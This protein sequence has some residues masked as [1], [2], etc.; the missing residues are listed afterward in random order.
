MASRRRLFWWTAGLA[1]AALG[2]IAVRGS[3]LTSRRSPWPGEQR[4]ALVGRRFLTPASVRNQ[5][6]PLPVTPEIVR[7][8]MEH[9]ADHCATCHGNDGSGDVSMG[10]NLFP[11][12]P[13]MR[14]N[15]TQAM[16]DGELF[17]AIERGIPFTG[18]PAWGTGT[19]EGEEATW[20]LVRFIRHLPALTDDE[21]HAMEVLNPISPAEQREKKAIDDFLSG[22][23]IR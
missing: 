13:D 16:T 12:A 22:K 7:A 15:P 11:P 17:Y 9:F 8:G 1:V 4:L 3:G 23:D 14:G 6:N 18:M 2:I 5:Q 20:A 19:P 10:R 21:R